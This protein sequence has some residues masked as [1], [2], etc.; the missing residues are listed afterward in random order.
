MEKRDHRID[1]AKCILI[2]FVVLGH[3]L[4]HVT[5]TAADLLYRT[6][7]LYHMPLF[8]FIT[9]LF[10]SR[11]SRRS[12]WRL[13]W[14]Y[15]VFQTAYPLYNA[16]IHDEPMPAL[17]Y[18]TPYWLL[19]YLLCT[20]LY[21]LTVPLIDTDRPKQQ[22]AIL[23]AASAVSLLA[24]F[25]QTVG[26]YMTLSR[27]FTFYPFF[28]LGFYAQKNRRGIEGLFRERKW[29]S[30]VLP[31]GFCLAVAVSVYWLRAT[32]LSWSALYGSKSYS[33]AG[34]TVG[35][36]ALMLLFGV[37]GIG[38]LPLIP[39][40]NI[41]VISLIGRNSLAVFLLHGFI[42]KYFG[43]NSWEI[44]HFP[45]Y[46]NLLLAAVMAAGILLLLGN[47]W[48]AAVVDF[49][50]LSWSAKNRSKKDRPGQEQT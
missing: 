11:R 15:A 20:I 33:A 49:I 40:K 2:Y 10:A 36:K 47:R 22:M 38:L 28:L 21:R 32:G 5:G 14:L 41:P 19:W 44:F 34:Y 9:G 6:I 7:Y 16:L 39:Q 4:E 29:L 18:T 35:M 31:L 37:C 23:L 46:T 3:F 48:A 24:G 45:I 43:I 17:Q 50:G 26:Y 1:N 13:I 42:I 30:R 12:D 8:I 27:F 25:E